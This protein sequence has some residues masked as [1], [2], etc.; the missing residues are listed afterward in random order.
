MITIAIDKNL[1][2]EVYLDF[3]DFAVAGMDFGARIRRDHPAVTL[4]NHEQYITDFYKKNDTLLRSAVRELQSHL[5]QTQADFFAAAEAV[6]HEDYSG[7]TFTG[8]LSIFDCNPRYPER[9]LFQIC[10]QRDLLGKGEVAYHEV[11]HFL[12]FRYCTE[13][14]ADVIAGYDQNSGPYWELSEIWNVIILNEP[15][16]QNILKREEHMFYPH[17]EAA[18][19]KAKQVWT[20]SGSVREFVVKML[21]K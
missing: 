15:A 21:S 12:F 8:V 1:D 20:E 18:L 11:M 5:D 6:Y 3:A 17:L 14:C 7:R 13:H 10:Y 16:F 2:K 9:E 4:E 19:P